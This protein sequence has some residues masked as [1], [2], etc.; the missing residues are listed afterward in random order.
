MHS[1]DRIN[2]HSWISNPGPEVIKLL[3]CWTRLSRKFILLINVKIVGILTFIT[4]INATSERLKARNC[5]ICWYF[6]FYEQLKFHAKLREH[7]KMFLTLGPGP[8]GPLAL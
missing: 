2:S 5:F 1:P 6:S 8:N 7:E 4:M 3:Q